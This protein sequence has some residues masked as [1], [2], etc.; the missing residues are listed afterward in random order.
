M[1]HDM[2]AMDIGYQIEYSGV[3]WSNGKMEYT[4]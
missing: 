2:Q 1:V 4:R 3:K